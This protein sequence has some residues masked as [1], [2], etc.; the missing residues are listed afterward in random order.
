MISPSDFGLTTLR[1][2]ESSTVNI[3]T[4]IEDSIPK[5]EINDELGILLTPKY[6]LADILITTEK[7]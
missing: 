6:G 4:K 7:Y 5:N 2:G 1:I 3:E